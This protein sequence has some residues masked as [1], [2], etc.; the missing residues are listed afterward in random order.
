MTLLREWARAIRFWSTALIVAWL[1]ASPSLHA[2]EKD[3]EE[4][5]KLPELMG[6]KL[7]KDEYLI[8]NAR[9]D[10][11]HAEFIRS[12]RKVPTVHPEGVPTSLI[13]E[14]YLHKKSQAIETD[15]CYLESEWIT[16]EELA[17]LAAVVRK[18]TLITRDLFKFE[19]TAPIKEVLVKTKEDYYSLVDAWA[20]SDK[21]RKQARHA[22]SAFVGKYRC[23]Y[24]AEFYEAL[25]LVAA[26]AVTANLDPSFWSHAALKEG[27]HTYLGSQLTADYVHYFSLDAT[28]PAPKRITGVELLIET[29][30]EYLSRSKRDSLD[31]ILRSELNTLSPERLSVAFALINFILEKKRDRW[32]IFRSTL[33]TESS[34]NG[35]LKGPEGRWAALVQAIKV[36]FDLG[37]QDLEKELQNF[38]ATHYLYTEEIAALLGIDRECADSTFQGFVTICELKRAKKPVSEKGEKLYQ[39]I[40]GRMEKKLQTASEKF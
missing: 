28:T 33:A 39:D 40:L 7:P 8:F 35:K 19:D 11:A 13:I 9:V 20:E 26:D 32:E 38:T 27:L 34:E 25:T 21:A 1:L 16:A 37:I 18:M 36:A 30:K 2:Q 6:H 31:I 24:R 10:R 22:L 23:G 3:R 14:K 15:F 5:V 4:F 17:T 12:L 29:A